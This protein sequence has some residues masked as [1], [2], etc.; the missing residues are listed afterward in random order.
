MLKSS[1]SPSWPGLPLLNITVT[2]D[3]G[4]VSFVVVKIPSVFP[5]SWFI[6]GFVSRATCRPGT[7]YHSEAPEFTRV[8]YWGSCCSIFNFLCNVVQIIFCPFVLFLLA[9][10]LSVLLQ[11]TA[12]DYPFA[13]FKH[14]LVNLV[15]AIPRVSKHS[16]S[17]LCL[18]HAHITS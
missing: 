16:I 5:L 10:V 9:I 1:R 4:Y 15:F 3:H 14:F 13:I 7:V 17:I 12:S 11:I 18:S 8:V 6:T 2:D